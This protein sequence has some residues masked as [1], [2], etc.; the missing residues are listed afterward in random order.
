MGSL[1]D[2]YRSITL[3]I[4]A[5]RTGSS[6]LQDALYGTREELER[7]GIDI[8]VPRVSGQ[9][10]YPDHRP[11]LNNYLKCF[12]GYARSNLF[13]RPFKQFKLRQAAQAYV[14]FAP[15]LGS[16]LIVSEEN[17]LGKAAE[18]GKPGQL[19]PESADRLVAAGALCGSNLARVVLSIRNYADFLLSYELMQQT[20]SSSGM[21]LE[22]L[23]E[24][25][26]D[27][28]RG[29]PVL[30]KTLSRIYPQARL[31]IWPFRKFEIGERLSNLTDGKLHQSPEQRPARSL[32]AAPTRE[33]LDFLLSLRAKGRLDKVEID[34]VLADQAAGTK[35]TTDVCFPDETLRRLDVSY[36][37][38]CAEIAALPNVEYM[39]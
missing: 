27:D 8:I 16:S 36:E 6:T 32:N 19:Y 22:A 31:E 23:R 1:S 26:K 12:G 30:V 9:R 24:W 17:I 11:V 10:D 39:P 37:R 13:V 18:I 4:G 34:K 20:Y 15:R 3:H 14:S 21:G 29:W 33:T 2:H 25:A 7:I 38:D 28:I 35:L 5:H